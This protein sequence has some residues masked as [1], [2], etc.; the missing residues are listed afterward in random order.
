M[1]DDLEIA[2]GGPDI[3]AAEYVIG[4]L[5]AAEAD[6][7]RQRIDADPA[8]AGLVGFWEER[9]YPLTLLVAP[10]APPASLWTRIE[11]STAGAAVPAFRGAAGARPANDNAAGWRI[12][13]LASMAI[14]AG[15]AAFIVLRPPPRP[16]V[17]EA[18][19]SRTV[20]AVLSP[21][22]GGAAV[23]VA[24][25]DPSG[26]LQIRPTGAIAVPGDR[27]LQLWS[28]PT[29]A[30]KP[31][32][33]GVLPAGGTQVPGTL[34]IGTQLLVSLEPKGGSP[35]GQPTGPVLY[36]GKLATFQ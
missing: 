14:A 24:V 3:L 22:A 18:V 13:A 33:L 20:L 17:A 1:S 7:A 28:L 21:A 5:D 11:D 27:D 25:A 4:T 26:A 6:A 30:A 34:A 32:S 19:V 36:A 9:L 23:L 16:I 31:A 8:F 12:A 10:L 15:L 29:G 35:T 2:G